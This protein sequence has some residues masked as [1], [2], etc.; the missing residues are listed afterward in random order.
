MKNCWKCAEQIQEEAVACRFCH[1]NQL[2]RSAGAAGAAHGTPERVE[3]AQPIKTGFARMLVA[4]ALLLAVGYAWPGD[5]KPASPENS[6]WRS[7]FV[8]VPVAEVIAAF[9]DNEVAAESRF[10]GSTQQVAGVVSEINAGFGDTSN[11][12]LTGDR[13]KDGRLLI[14]LIDGQRDSVTRI[15]KGQTIIVQC[16]K[17]T[18]FLGQPVASDCLVAVE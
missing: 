7:G 9:D 8:S 14:D 18:E 1:A 6:T 11:L 4:V 16:K 12:V 15:K 13:R 10:G 5:N 2:S 17:I 3:A